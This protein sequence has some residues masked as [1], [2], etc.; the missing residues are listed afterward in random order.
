MEIMHV[1]RH[2][3]KKVLIIGQ[4]QPWP[5]RISGSVAGTCIFSAFSELRFFGLRYF[6]IGT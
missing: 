1:A 2:T 4:T 3:H 5:S 6:A